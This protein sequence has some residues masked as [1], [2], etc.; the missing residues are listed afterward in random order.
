MSYIYEALKK[1]QK[2]RTGGLSAEVPSPAFETETAPIF[3]VRKPVLVDVQEPPPISATTIPDGANPFRLEE[4]RASCSRFVF[5]ANLTAYPGPVT[6]PFCEEQFRTLRSRLYDL[7]HRQQ[8]R[9]ILVTS[10]S[11]GEG[12]TFVVSNLAK[13]FASQQDCSILIIDADLRR[14]RVNTVLGIAAS[15]GLSE[16]LR[17][18]ANEL[19]TIQ[20]G[21]INPGGT[22]GVLPAGGKVTNPN[23]LLSNGRMATLLAR[24]GPAFDWIIIDSPPCL[25][26][27]DASVIAEHCDGSLIVIQVGTTP[28]K[29]LGKAQQEL[30]KRNILGIVM[31]GVEEKEFSYS[32]YCDDPVGHSS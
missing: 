18:E 15:P 14:S 26:V 21:Q 12:K 4:L 11:S 9:T 28:A 23:E 29:L 25:P 10:P 2:E 19:A 22:L 13:A 32:P 24:V 20:L 30:S 31:N 16:Y 7:R 6:S 1:A 27:A 5:R 8:L 17:A 3:E